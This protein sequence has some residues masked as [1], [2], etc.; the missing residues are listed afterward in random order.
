[1]LVDDRYS[2]SSPTDECGYMREK[3]QA[4]IKGY[5]SDVSP[6]C[7]NS[8]VKHVIEMSFIEAHTVY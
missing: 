8:K 3:H 7:F 1:M 6:R 5:D 2:F 4:Q